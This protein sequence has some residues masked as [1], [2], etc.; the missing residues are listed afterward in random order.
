M[1]A[2]YIPLTQTVLTGT[3]ASV[4]L[5]GIP[6]TYTDLILL[7]SAK[8]DRV[9][10]DTSWVLTFNSAAAGYSYTRMAGIAGA[11]QSA[12]ASAASN[13]TPNYSLVG[14]DAT[15]TNIFTNTEIYI[16]NY[17]TSDYKPLSAKNVL[18]EN[19]TSVNTRQI[20]SG[21]FSDTTAITSITIANVGAFNFVSGSSFYLYGIS[22][23]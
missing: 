3:Q 16:S 6:Q 14:T 4:T 15:T 13:I 22:N 21:Q 9:S 2:T 5:S 23:A 8:S 1:P 19:S 10:P 12:R 17:A 20:V 11:T 7:M 18:E